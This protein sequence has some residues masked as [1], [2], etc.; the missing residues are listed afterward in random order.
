MGGDV[1]G[2][3]TVVDEAVV[4]RTRQ[5]NKK[6][7]KNGSRRHLRSLSPRKSGIEIGPI[8]ENIIFPSLRSGVSVQEKKAVYPWRPRQFSRRVLEAPQAIRAGG[9][10]VSKNAKGRTIITALWKLPNRYGAHRQRCLAAQTKDPK[11]QATCATATR[12]LRLKH[13]PC[14][15]YNRRS[16]AVQPTSFV[17]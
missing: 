17:V 3:Q 6:P 15:P 14:R 12:T 13:T 16:E 1:R 11:H 8:T 7:K 4:K 9:V 5:G 10:A 2:T